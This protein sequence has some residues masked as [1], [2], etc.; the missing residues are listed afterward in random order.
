MCF[1]NKDCEI[2]V[3]YSLICK[4]ELCSLDRCVVSLILNI[5]FKFKKI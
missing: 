1:E 3:Y 5:F 2:F 4:W